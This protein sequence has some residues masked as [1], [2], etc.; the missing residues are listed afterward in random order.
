MK[1]NIKDLKSDDNNCTERFSLPYR[2]GV[3][4]MVINKDKEVFVGKRIDTKNDTWQMPQGGIK[5]DETVIEAGFRELQ[6]ETMINEVE[7]IAETKNWLYYDLP[8]FLIGKLWE[9]RYRGQKQKWLLMNFFGNDS[10]IDVKTS[11]AEFK[12][13]NWLELDKIPEVIIPF[14]KHLYSSVVEEFRNII[15][16]FG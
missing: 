6:E 8:E 14:K 5:E 11:S 12:K 4:L 16:N 7:V 9:G 3:G 13:W 10:A 15:K 1:E 2:R